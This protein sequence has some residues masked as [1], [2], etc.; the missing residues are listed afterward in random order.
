[1]V[2]DIASEMGGFVLQLAE[3]ILK[4]IVIVGTNVDE[5]PLRGAMNKAKRTRIYQKL[6]FIVTDAKHLAFKDNALSTVSSHFRFDI[7]PETVSAFEESY[8]F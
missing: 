7:V 6:S 3:K 4:D 1:M 2:L 5:K 8:R